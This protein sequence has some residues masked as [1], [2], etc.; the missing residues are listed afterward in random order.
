VFPIR[1]VIVLAIKALYFIG[2][3]MP[4]SSILVIASSIFSLGA[5]ADNLR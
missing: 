1:S 3:L 2:C 4:A 5:K